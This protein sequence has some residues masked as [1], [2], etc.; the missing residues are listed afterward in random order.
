[1]RSEQYEVSD[2]CVAGKELRTFAILC[3]T[4]LGILV[5]TLLL[6]NVRLP[7][8]EHSMIQISNAI[9][10]ALQNISVNGIAFGDL[11]V[12]GVSKYLA[13]AYGYPDSAALRLQVTGENYESIPDDYFGQTPLG[14]GK[15]TYCIV[16]REFR[17][18]IYFEIGTKQCL[19]STEHTDSIRPPVPPN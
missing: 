3:S 8:A 4:L 14:A 9:R 6:A 5:A 12:G 10:I 7:L 2:G 18:N 19:T 1:M 13:L 11:P 16:N 15:F 17:G